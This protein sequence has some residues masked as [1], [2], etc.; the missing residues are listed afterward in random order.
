MKI[1][2][3]AAYIDIFLARRLWNWHSISYST[4]QYAT[5]LLMRDVRG[6][7]PDELIE[8]L[9]K[10]LNDEIEGFT[11]NE[12]FKLNLMNRPYI[13]WLLARMTEYIQIQSGEASH[14]L[15]Y[16]GIEKGQKY[17]VEHI[18]A[19]HPEWHT[20]EFT[21]PADFQ[22]Y[23]NRIGGLLLLP[24]SFNAS[25]G[26]L[27]YEDKLKHYFGQNLLARSLHEK[28]YEHHPRFEQFLQ[29]SA[30]PFEAHEHFM[31]AD[32]ENRQKLYQ[33]IAEQIWNP[34]RLDKETGI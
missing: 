28:C 25:Y 19:N 4:L 1:K 11:T 8:I 2:I 15:E 24:K 20:S 26:D 12:R 22:E 31:K 32:L 33:D 13:H 9:K 23:R 21:H 34:D 14:Y 29:T 18:W 27:P 5:F 16:M 7:Q 30:L 3:V 6:K 10:R 17:E